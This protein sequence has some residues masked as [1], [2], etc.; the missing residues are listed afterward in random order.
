[1]RWPG[2][3][4]AGLVYRE[5][6]SLLDVLPTSAALADAKLPNDRIYD[7]IDIMP[8]L[9]GQATGTPHDMLVWRRR[10]LVSIRKGDWKLWESVN[11][12]TGEYGEY[13]LLFNL[14]TDLNEATN[15]AARNP[16]KVKE[17]EVL[18]HQ[19]AKDMTDPKWPSRPPQKIDVCGTP[20]VL[21]I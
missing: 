12:S 16:E 3:I 10:P 18:V 20:F 5:V 11:D 7:G 13:K 14:R 15:L 1:M 2:H 17:L 9:T 19:W 21:P 4:K 8:F 6:V